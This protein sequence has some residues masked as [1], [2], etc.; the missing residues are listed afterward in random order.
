[1]S[2][3]ATLR[4]ERDLLGADLGRYRVDQARPQIWPG[5]AYYA[6]DKILERQVRITAVFHGEVGAQQSLKRLRAGFLI[7][8]R[9]PAPHVVPTI[10]VLELPHLT[11]FVAGDCAT[12]TVA[13]RVSENG[14]LPD[15]VA[16]RAA[17]QLLESL[18]VVHRAGFVHRALVPDAVRVGTGG[19]IVIDHFW[20]AHPRAGDPQHTPG[21][22][23]L[24]SPRLAPEIVAGFPASWA[25]DIWNWAAMVQY[26]LTGMFPLAGTL[27]P[28]ESGSHIGLLDVHLPRSWS[29]AQ[30]DLLRPLLEE[31][32]NAHP[33]NR[34]G[35][36]ADVHEQFGPIVHQLS[37]QTAPSRAASAGNGRRPSGGYRVSGG[38]DGLDDEDLAIE[39][40][41]V[42]DLI[43]ERMDTTTTNVESTSAP[44]LRPALPVENSPG[45][46]MLNEGS[47]RGRQD[48]H[49]KQGTRELDTAAIG[50]ESVAPSSRR[51]PPPTPRNTGSTKL[52]PPRKSGGTSVSLPPVPRGASPIPAAGDA[53]DIFVSA[54]AP[55]VTDGL[56]VGDERRL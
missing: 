27:S 42:E 5:H 53:D 48:K 52:P 17:E 20:F 15:I 41:I 6:W 29:A 40:A 54:D 19:R 22:R 2:N 44:D 55:T 45:R 8:S 25:T 33:G 46:A 34:P 50:R 1:M 26:L 39:E 14:P 38:D 12:P 47:S 21:E 23:L 24:E 10:D 16:L 37:A 7:Q 13:T 18:E 49:A 30:Q 11:A 31:C 32:L 28:T 51:S 3:L 4:T 56:L 43:R 36:A 35:T 9:L